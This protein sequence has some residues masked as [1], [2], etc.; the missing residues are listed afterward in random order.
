MLASLTNYFLL[1]LVF[2]TCQCVPFSFTHCI[3]KGVIKTTNT[4]KP[5]SLKLTSTCQNKS[6]QMV[7]AVMKLRDIYSLKEKL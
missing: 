1:S 3:T 6:L 7:T 5:F 4:N 2:F